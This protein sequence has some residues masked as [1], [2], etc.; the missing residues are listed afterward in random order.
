MLFRGCQPP[1]L[2]YFIPVVRG[3]PQS[4]AFEVERV[5]VTFAKGLVTGRGRS[6]FHTVVWRVL[7]RPIAHGA[8]CTLVATQWPPVNW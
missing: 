5:P 2:E 3:S 6:N 7:P 4:P 1:T 8:S